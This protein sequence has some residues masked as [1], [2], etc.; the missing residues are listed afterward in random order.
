M[1]KRFE[2]K[3]WGLALAFFALVSLVLLVGALQTMD[4]RPA[5]PIGSSDSNARSIDLSPV[6]E[7][8][9]DAAEVPFWNQVIFWGGLFVIVLLISSLLSPELRKK[10]IKTF[11]RYAS[12]TIIFLYLIKKNPDILAGLFLKLQPL[13]EPTNTLTGDE[14]PQPV[15]RPPQIPSLLS[16]FVT[17]G[18]ILLGIAL[19]WILNRWWEKQKELLSARQPLK[20][21]AD[22]ARLSLKNIEAGE[23]S[24]DVI[25]QCYSRMSN[26]VN[27]K[28]GLQRE[29]YMT[30]AEFASRLERAGL[31][32]EP[33]GRLT[34]LFES[35]RYGGHVSGTPEVGEA[36]SCLTSILKY[37]G[38]V[39]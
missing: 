13:G 2:D 30:P 7:L 20:D 21:I 29:Y 10:L 17:F 27:A 14:I 6:A 24:K 22:I 36:V 26:V 32:R 25:I 11:I 35:V 8:L 4:F 12:F 33:V 9:T 16:F 37:C 19:L 5:Q 31:P 23:D 39:Q 1:R 34:H 15:F 28:H 3:R 18:L 38:E